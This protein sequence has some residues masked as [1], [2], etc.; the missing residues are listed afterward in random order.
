[1][2]LLISPH[3]HCES[4]LTGSPLSSMIKKAVDLGRTH[5][6]YT[7]LG[8]LSSCLKA[9]GQAKAANLKFAAGIEFYFKDS[10]CPIVVGTK[11]DRCNYF[12][13][14]IFAK[15]QD[16]YQ[17]IV[18]VVSSNDMPKIKVRDKSDPESLWSWK[19]LERLSKVD[20]VLV[21]GGPHCMVGKTLLA[22]TPEL[23]EKVLLKLHELFGDRL[24]MSLVC[25]PWAKKYAKVVKI[26]YKDGT[27]DS[28]LS[29]D[30]V[31]TNKARK[32]KAGDL[33][34]RNGHFLI[35]SKVVGST[36]Y[37][38]DKQILDVTEHSGFLPLPVDVTLVVNKFFI[39]M[40]KKHRINLLVSDYAFYSEK[41]DHIVQ[42]MVLEGS[43]KLK[44][45]LHMKS[46]P[47]IRSYLTG[48]LGLTEEESDKIIGNNNEWSK[49]FDTFEL[50]Y[51]WRLADG[52]ENPL[53]QC[54]EII[55]KKGL[56]CWK[57][58]VWVARLKEEFDVIAKNGIFNLSPYFLPIHDVID[59]YE[60]NGK[61][62]GP[63]RGSA[64]GSL[65]AY[66]MG[67]TKV[68]PFEFDLSFNRFY[69]MD[70]IKALK[71][72][73]IDTDLESRDLLVG[74][75]GESGYL[76]TRWGNRAAQVSTRGKIRLK[77][78]IKDTNRYINGSVEKS[79]ELLTKSLPDAGQGI[80]DEQFIFGMEDDDGNHIDGLIETSEPLQRYA[81]ERPKEWAIVRQAL[82]ITRAFSRHACA[83]VIADKPISEIVPIKDGNV[84]QYEATEAEK[85]GLIK[86]DF[87]VIS[88]L[89]DLRVCLDLINKKNKE[90]HKTGYFTHD[91][92]LTYIWKLPNDSQAYKS[93]WE[94][95]TES[96]FQINT[97]SMIPFVKS[98]KPE[99]I[100]DLSIILSLVRPGPLDYIDEATG[101]SMAEEYVH[102]R[103]GGE[104]KDVNILKELIPQTHS[105]LVYQEQVTKIAKSLAGFSGSA[106]ENLREVIGKK[107]RS[108]I[109]K[110]KPDFIN[111][112]VQSNK[113][114]EDEAKVLWDRIVT[115]GRYAFNKSHGV[116]YAFITYACIF[117]KHHYPLEFWAAV[118]TNAKEKEI[119]GKLWPYVKHLVAAPDIN[120]ST[121]EMEIDYANGKIRA[122]LGVIKGMAG[123]TTDPIVAGRPYKD[124]QDFVSKEVAGDSV[125]RK[126]IHVGVLD[127][128]FPPKL[129]LLDK[130]QIFED[131][132]EQNKFDKKIAKAIQEGKKS[133]LEAPHKGE[134]K[135][136]YLEIEKNPLKNAAVQKS[137]LPS[138]LVGLR[139]LGMNY[140]SLMDR[141]CDFK[142]A[143]MT[144]KGRKKRQQNENSKLRFEDEDHVVLLSGEEFETI[145]LKMS[146]ESIKDIEFAVFGYVV[147][148]SIFDYSQNTK[149]ALK[150]IIDVDG[151]VKE[152]VM[153]PNY[154]SK[155]LEYPSELKKGNICMFFMQKR[156]GSGDP[157][158]IEEIVIEA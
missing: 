150:V 16:S 142:K 149:Q 101:R 93:V 57:D 148:T 103:D 152:H 2:T 106:A 76:Y 153:W 87:L 32:I 135:E 61:M 131:L 140:S 126:L 118:L 8:H 102:R 36:F 65:V 12:T 75:D 58:P 133:R 83:F 15:N 71:L 146:S 67:V 86:Y 116:S 98:I 111:G 10:F 139:N 79:I 72:A 7:D 14:S 127:S 11:A 128:L 29:S 99:N 39:E 117:L 43:N 74:D 154:Y 49:N 124:I 85:A 70:R 33:T 56:M 23:A 63:G 64:A 82:G 123:A 110:I 60:E 97:S 112:C 144:R 5:F 90:K 46:E 69:S 25:E 35:K 89:K 125:T 115:F 37:D 18:R 68:D 80:T 59:H 55:K 96:C 119:S 66:L 78:A 17:E 100:E 22:D 137:I 122:K 44:A 13:A 94:G 26:K 121:D 138:L 105:V 45:D 38:V 6:S 113:V 158:V 95:S 129:G 9:Y 50:K 62:V 3:T 4:K 88:Q 24:S 54:I 19:D 136:E 120:L 141:K 134:I 73:D 130:M 77:S 91:G 40:S 34:T 20:T 92:K 48:K 51:K 41:E 1:M 81:A 107:K 42:T 27:S 52:G 30:L 114:T 28:I 84:V 157:A 108:T 156:Q 155:K 132:L 47:E 145:D 151:Y 109:L 31:T 104:Y 53:Q 143:V 147:G 21:L